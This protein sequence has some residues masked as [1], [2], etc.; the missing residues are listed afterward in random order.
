MIANVGAEFM[1]FGIWWD[2]G[3]M[4]KNKP[5]SARVSSMSDGEVVVILLYIRKWEAGP[6]LERKMTVNSI[7]E[8]LKDQWHILKY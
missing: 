1:G 7:C 8:I 6:K 4:K 5:D 3:V 2:K